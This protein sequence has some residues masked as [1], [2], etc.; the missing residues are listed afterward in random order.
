MKTLFRTAAIA[1]AST[2]LVAGGATAAT[3]APGDGTTVTSVKLGQ[4]ATYN[5]TGNQVTGTIAISAPDGLYSLKATVNVNGKPV[6]NGVTINN[7]TNGSQGFSYNRKWGAGVVSLTNFTANGPG[8]TNKP[9]PAP[10]NSTRVR[11]ALES[12]QG[13]YV[14]KRGKKMTF[15]ITATYRDKSEKRKSAKKATVQVKKGSKW[16]T[17]K[18]VKLNSKGQASFKRKDGKK[19]SYRVVVKTT[20]TFLGGNTKGLKI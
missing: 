7:Y 19:R 1:V 13:I 6:A 17:L 9:V 2:A 20:N 8:F 5:K 14:S 15:K 10:A 11:Y 3:A 12:R 4:S 16:K 18:K